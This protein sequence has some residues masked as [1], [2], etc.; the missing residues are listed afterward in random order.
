MKRYLLTHPDF[1]IFLGYFN[2]TPV[3]T[4]ATPS[5]ALPTTA[6]VFK[7]PQEIQLFCSKTMEW[8]MPLTEA[9]RLAREVDS[10]NDGWASIAACVRSGVEMWN[11]VCA[12]SA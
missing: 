2:S 11:C 5:S 1:G 3:W 9:E 8:D 10:D 4:F 7:S 6:A 12:G